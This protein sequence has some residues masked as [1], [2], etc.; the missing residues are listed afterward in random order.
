[1]RE[2]WVIKDIKL[3]IWLTQLGISIAAP[4]AGFLLLAI[5]LYNRFQLG[6]WVILVGLLLGI[7][8][9]VDGFRVCLRAMQLQSKNNH[10]QEPPP[11][12]FNDHH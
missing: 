5:W 11:V 2:V 1:M 4:L 6:P 12:S 8:G 7:S 3:L 10:P 9:A